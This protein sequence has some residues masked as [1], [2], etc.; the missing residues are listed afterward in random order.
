MQDTAFRVRTPSVVSEVIDGEAIIMDM[1]SG[2]Y[3]SAEGVGALIWQ[4]ICDGAS[5]SA[6]LSWVGQ[7]YPAA[8]NPDAASAF[9]DELV[10][11]ELIEPG[12][13]EAEPS[14]PLSNLPDWTPPTLAAHEDMQD[15]IT[16]DP[17]H[18]VDEVG[19]PVRKTEATT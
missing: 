17:I 16:L 1:R 15:L 18:D 13:A 4:A 2:N 9:I 12:P 10:A 14:F 8:A 11:R 7:A 6:I 5:T 3:F 19:W